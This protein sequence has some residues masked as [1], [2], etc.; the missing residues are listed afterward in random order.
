M[1]I[2]IYPYIYIHLYV[3]SYLS[4]HLSLSL[5]LSLTPTHAVG[6]FR[7]QR[8]SVEVSTGCLQGICLLAGMC[9]INGGRV[10]RQIR[11]KGWNYL[12]GVSKVFVCVHLVV[13]WNVR[14]KWRECTLLLVE[15]RGEIWK[16][17]LGVSKVI[18]VKIFVYV[19]Q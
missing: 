8:R 7:N 2:S 4:R 17:P 15:I 18:L 5:S 10:P 19:D 12:L 16:Y 3:Y 11:G 9:E 14:D 6:A 1:S 13:V